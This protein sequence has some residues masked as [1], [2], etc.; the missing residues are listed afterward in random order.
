MPRISVILTSFNHEKYLGESIDS[1]L[2][3]TYQDYELIILDDASTD[4]SWEIILGYDDPRIIAISSERRG[5]VASQI[6]KA[7]M[8]IASGEFICIHHSD[9]IWESTK[10]E[11]QLSHIDRNPHVAAVFTNA[12]PIME[13]GQ[14]LSDRTHFYADVF[15]Q[16]NRSRYEWLR[17][18]LN[19]G[20]ALCHSSVLIRRSSYSECGIYK[21]YLLQSDDFDM[22]VRLLLKHDIY[23]LPE[24]LVRFRIRENEAN[25]SGNR[26][27]SRIRSIY[28]YHLLLRNYRGIEDFA[29]LVKI[30]PSAKN[31]DRGA[32]TDIQFALAMTILDESTHGFGQLFALDLLFELVSDQVHAQKLKK[33]YDFNTMDFFALTGQYDVF[34]GE[35]IAAH[36]SHIREL[37]VSMSRFGIQIESQRN[38]LAAYAL[39]ASGMLDSINKKEE[40][41]A[42]AYEQ[43]KTQSTELAAYSTQAATLTGQIATQVARITQLSQEL[44]E[45][46]QVNA[47]LRADLMRH[48]MQV[49]ELLHNAKRR[50]G[51]I[52]D[53][54]QKLAMKRLDLDKLH[55]ESIK[56][57]RLLAEVRAAVSE[58]E[59]RIAALEHESKEHKNAV[60]A[61]INSR[62]W[63]L[64]KPFRFTG[65]LLRGEFATAFA[66]FRKRRFF[67]S[68][69][70][71]PVG[72]HLA[73][74]STQPAPLATASVPQPHAPVGAEADGFDEDFYLKT[75]PDVR[76][77]GLDAYH[78]YVH[79][80]Q[81]EGRL[82]CPP[83]LVLEPGV[84][85]IDESRK[86]VLIVSHDASRTGAPILS[87]NIARELQKRFNV[88]VLLLGGGGLASEF[89]W[90]ASWVV[91]AAGA[92]SSNTEA[93]RTIAELCSLHVFQFAIV[94]T[95]ESRIV[96]KPLTRSSVPTVGLI[97][98]FAAYT[99]PRGAFPFAAG[100][101]TKIVFSTRITRDNALS[102]YPEFVGQPWPILPQGRCD[103]LPIEID[104]V[105][106][107]GEAAKIRR[108]LRPDADAE[109]TQIVVIG[110]GSVQ[111]RKGVDLFLECAA[112]V[113]QSPIGRNCQFVWVG[114][115]YD[116]EHDIG[117]SVYLAE[118]IRRAGLERHVT[119]MPETPQIDDVY[120]LADML[121]LSSRLDPLPNV[122][123]DAMF[124]GLPVVCFAE[125]SGIADAL[126]DSGLA[127]ECVAPYQ[128]AAAMARLV[129]SLAESPERRG[130]I[131]KR[132]QRA[133]QEKFN[134]GAYVSEL[135]ALAEQARHQMAD[136]I[137]SA[138]TILGAGVL[139][140]TFFLRRADEYQ[141][142]DDAVRYGYVRSWACGI[143]RRKPFPGFHPGIYAEHAI[144]HDG[145]GLDPLAH[146]LRAGQP[147][148][149][150]KFDVIRS[151]DVA[152]PVPAELRVALHLHVYYPELID[153]I[154]G[155]L[156]ANK[157]RPDLYISVPS[158]DVA[159]AV[160]AS[161]NAHHLSVTAVEVVPNAGR[162]LGPLF[163]TFG[164]V[165]TERYDVIGHL[166]TKK[167][168]DVA[169]EAMGKTWQRF[170]M[171]NLLGGKA[172]MADLIL[173]RMGADP[174]IGL[175][176]PDDPHVVGWGANRPYA[177]ALATRFGLPESQ[178]EDLAFPVGSMFWARV[179]ALRP[180]FDLGL[181]WSDYP[182][183][184]L[185]Y[186]GS[187]LHAIERLLSLVAEH[188]STR[189]VLTHVEGET[190]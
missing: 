91:M 180:L 147:D 107:A 80:G 153:D 125:A 64:T 174:T 95:I 27:D 29:E 103:P 105:I 109:R 79:H 55:D 102:E 93:D 89:R 97:H 160:H 126:V 21:L 159:N 84:R 13:D 58:Q 113:I 145:N 121:L 2:A 168:I 140:T 34:S 18:F 69:T 71:A 47:T 150:W 129:L 158:A 38:E 36:E 118:Q 169:D 74:P 54:G 137:E 98:E 17:Y 167:S 104:P 154:F 135:E 101:S 106:K 53:V 120:G 183:E 128:D 172:C 185:P 20:N 50:D 68:V 62:S 6:N 90:A 170:L 26:R 136:E 96:L 119:F 52:L 166:H 138:E 32:E 94:N 149:P 41:L 1:V 124:H 157:E 123:I 92:R 181:S 56:K 35:T 43:I 114:H 30:F 173:G 14:P 146:Y 37:N 132:L 4:K 23:I 60:Q 46:E 151:R 155:R 70:T 45:R 31:Y 48:Q 189:I 40:M 178:P 186:D 8:E 44:S 83:K 39:Q 115:G 127:D 161:A 143:D 190:R 28:E 165:F 33:I 164:A 122:A 67:R 65:R 25:I 5:Q 177:Q 61:L 42:Q 148:G 76:A 133:A 16:P 162:D 188:Q 117:Y 175:V 141:S 112:H 51:I 142:L 24:R 131:G 72:H 156:A 88:V 163:T 139:D 63:K 187:M 66:P 144:G 49:A 81:A 15:N 86:A 176:F 116:P 9:D 10:L 3:Q 12:Q 82:G 182:P 19:G 59:A 100:W 171:E 184:P 99:R 77:S 11:R 87:L 73:T 111:Y 75:Y 57:D 85:P 7:I 130:Q 108:I 78:H 110:A 179:D 134:M 152:L 22:W